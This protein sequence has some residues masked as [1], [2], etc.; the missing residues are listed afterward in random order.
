MSRTRPDPTGMERL[1]SS[2]RSEN[3]VLIVG[4]FLSGSKV[5]RG[6]CEELAARLS[7]KD[8]SVLTTSPKV[9][10]PSRV[11]DMASTAWRER[12]RYEVAQVDVYSGPAFLWAEIVCWVLR[13]AGKPYILTLHGGNLPRFAKDRPRR[14][15]RLL[16]SANAVTVPS[17]YLLEEMKAYREDL[18]LLPNGIDIQ[19]YK[20]RL[21][22]RPAPRLL[23]LRAFH[24]I[25][26]PSLA[27]RVLALLRPQFPGIRLAMIGPDKGDG[28]A[29]ATRRIAKELGV[30]DLIEWSAGISKD[31]VPGALD[32]ADIFLNTTNFDNSPVS[33]VEALA[34]GLCVV[35]TDA[36][37]MPYL[38]THQDNALLV[39]CD[40][41]RAMAAAVARILTEPHLAGRLSENGRRLA[42]D[43]DWERVLPEWQKLIGSLRPVHAA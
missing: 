26:N 28:S 14:V 37:G 29:D 22:D 34:S 18:Q 16:G 25:Y 15:R 1:P 27:P 9:P 5:T 41:A 39:P 6:V 36:G 32:Q 42:E 23:W 30:F 2:N 11:L 3:R 7:E 10:R 12:Y 33:V 13:R 17:R 4:N 35:S 8:W 43:S 19:L 20:Y 24:E 40:D 31:R 21:R 38:L